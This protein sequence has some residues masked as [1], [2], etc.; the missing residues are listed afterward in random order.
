MK[1]N[2]LFI[3]L[4]TVFE[5]LRVGY[6]S[7]RD[8]FES[9]P[10]SNGYIPAAVAFANSGFVSKDIPGIPFYPPF[11]PYLMS[12]FIEVFESNWVLF[13]QLTQSIFIV[14][15][16]FLILN[17]ASKLYGREIGYFSALVFVIS[18]ALIVIPGEATP[19]SLLIFTLSLYLFLVVRVL[20]NLSLL[21]T[22]DL[23]ALAFV[24]GTFYII[25]P[26]IFPIHFVVILYIFLF[27][28]I[29]FIKK[30]LFLASTLIPYLVFGLRN[31]LANGDL[32][33][34][35]SALVAI[36]GGHPISWSKFSIG[37][38][39]YGYCPDYKCLFN[40]IQAT[41][42]EW[43]ADCLNSMISFWTPYSG[44]NNHGNWFHNISLLAQLQKYG[45]TEI[46]NVLSVMLSLALFICFI[47]GGFVIL[48]EHQTTKVLLLVTILVV[49]GTETIIYGNSLHRLTI[50]PLIIPVQIQGLLELK[51]ILMHFYINNIRFKFKRV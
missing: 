19:E 3:S 50:L 24:G 51:R 11:Y 23:L 7:T 22:K 9:G 28:K 47:I 46:A 26:R 14:T 49:W 34:S 18:P 35:T 41:P 1:K 6:F 13:F 33:I 39:F 5:I 31:L 48:R 21:H 38:T 36:G 25:H 15:S 12:R 30:M 42:L 45:F 29:S 4:V 32:N 8:L 44:P 37:K 17:Y 2:W 16:A 43:I 27:F 10:D 20:P 40:Q